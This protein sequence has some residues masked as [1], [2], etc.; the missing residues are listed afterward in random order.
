M[1]S[2]RST[3]DDS[4]DDVQDDTHYVLGGDHLGIAI[5][6]QLQA[7]GQQV[8]IVGESHDLKDIPELVGDPSVLDVLS[9]SGIGAASTV[10]V[11][12]RSDRR[13][14]LV[15]QLV[16]TH[17]DVPR[18]IVLVNNPD[19]TALFADAGHEPFCVTTILS[20]AVSEAV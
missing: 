8:T 5:A 18:T 3:E 13:N 19:R 16:C 4:P 10:I 12:T 11:A 20:T 1:V 6:E 15:A 17:F 7:N 14:L 9:A 2:I